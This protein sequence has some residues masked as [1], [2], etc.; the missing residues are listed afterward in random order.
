MINTKTKNTSF[1]NMWRYLQNENI[2]NNDFMLRLR[3]TSL[4]DYK[5]RR[6]DKGDVLTNL[7]DSVKTMDDLRSDDYKRNLSEEI[8]ENIW[9]FFREI[10]CRKD[11]L[12]SG[13]TKTEEYPINYFY[14]HY[15]LNPA[16]MKMIYLYEHKRNFIVD[17]SIPGALETYCILLTY[18]NYYRNIHASSKFYKGSIRSSS[19]D[20][21]NINDILLENLSKY[22]NFSKVYIK[23][24]LLKNIITFSQ[25]KYLIDKDDINKEKNI[26]NFTFIDE[27][28][29]RSTIGAINQDLIFHYQYYE[30]LKDDKIKKLELQD[31]REYMIINTL[32]YPHYKFNCNNEELEMYMAWREKVFIYADNKIYD[33][34][35]D[36]DKCYIITE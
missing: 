30:P 29:D 4:L 24:E 33:E 28:T 26:F 15:T 19:G 36:D 11:D 20:D 5:W 12:A 10:L 13:K 31:T 16:T 32:T 14:R 34:L 6:Y 9:F 22:K 27:D 18:G 3:D 25:K 8:S 35:S 21:N 1:I 7:E 23:H 17:A 2:K